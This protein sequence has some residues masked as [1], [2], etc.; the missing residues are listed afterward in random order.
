MVKPH[1][2]AQKAQSKGQVRRLD[3]VVPQRPCSRGEVKFPFVRVR[4]HA[5][6]RW[7]GAKTNRG[8]RKKEDDNE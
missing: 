3:G 8:N 2:I 7:R 4:R 6:E 5:G 1:G